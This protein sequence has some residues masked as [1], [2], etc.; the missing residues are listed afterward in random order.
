MNQKYQQ[1][2]SKNLVCNKLLNTS[3]VHKQLWNEFVNSQLLQQLSPSKLFPRFREV[4]PYLI[5]PHRIE[6]TQSERG[7]SENIIT[8]RLKNRFGLPPVFS[9]SPSI[10]LHRKI[11]LWEQLLNVLVQRSSVIICVFSLLSITTYYSSLKRIE[12]LKVILVTLN[13]RLKLCDL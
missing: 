10:L 2:Q 1:N 13:L 6:M 5:Q 9:L 11:L 4:L 8:E 3:I 12:Q 7:K